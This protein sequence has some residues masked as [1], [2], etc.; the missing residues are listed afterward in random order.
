MYFTAH[1]IVTFPEEGYLIHGLSWWLALH[2]IAL[3][4]VRSHK[5]G[6]SPE[7]VPDAPSEPLIRS[8]P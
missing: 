6:A 2:L 1:L 7:I 4:L 8:A 5:A 3:A